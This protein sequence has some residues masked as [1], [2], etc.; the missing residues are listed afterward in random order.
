M[1]GVQRMM[2][3]YPSARDDR[4]LFPE[5]LAHASRSPKADPVTTLIRPTISVTSRYG[6]KAGMDVSMTSGLMASYPWVSLLIQSFHSI[7]ISD[8]EAG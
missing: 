7:L 4:I 1:D 3:V 5:S 6:S 2:Y 8:P